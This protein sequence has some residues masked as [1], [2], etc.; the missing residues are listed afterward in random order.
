M[1]VVKPEG[2]EQLRG[3]IEAQE[4]NQLPYAISKG[5]NDVAFAIRDKQVELISAVF[6]RP[7]PQTA[8]NIFV[9]KAT[10]TNLRVRIHFDQIYN[11]GIDEYMTANIDGGNRLMKPSEKRLGTY[12]V[13]GDGAKMDRYGNMQGGQITQILSRL[14]RFGDVAG[15]NTKQTLSSKLKRRGARKSLDYF[16]ISQRRGG[17]APG[18][19]QRTQRTG[20]GFGG[21]TSKH[22]PAGAFQKGRGNGRVNSVIQ[23]RGVLPIMLFVKQ[24][25][26]YKPVWPFFKAGQDIADTKLLPSV[27]NAIQ[28]ALRTAR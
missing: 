8:K 17:L 22:L 6:D 1:F 27:S 5:L 12:Y 3:Y 26:V 2:L 28:L 7:K 21:K 25:P 11:K 14:G 10:K 13:P 9:Q 16:M 20:T 18:I 4:R 15:Y 19:Y 24:A 23:M